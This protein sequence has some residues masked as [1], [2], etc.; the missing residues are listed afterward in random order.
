MTLDISVGIVS[1]GTFSPPNYMTAAEISK[2]AGVPEWVVRDKFGINKKHIG[3]PDDHPNEMGIK[4]ALDCLSQTDIPEINT[5]LLAGGYRV[6]DFINC[7]VRRHRRAGPWREMGRGGPCRRRAQAGHGGNRRRTARAPAQVISAFQSASQL[8]S[9]VRCP[10]RQQA[11]YSNAN[12]GSSSGNT[13]LA[14]KLQRQNTPISLFPKIINIDRDEGR[15]GNLPK[16]DGNSLV[17][18]N[19]V[20]AQRRHG[21]DA[22]GYQAAIAAR[23]C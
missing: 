1:V 17:F 13:S 19:R 12:Y 16:Q 22:P 8:C 5:V 15:L 11:R 10:F 14:R 4:A 21:Y 3:G 18:D 2:Q 20:G 7:P 6:C 23:M 9:S